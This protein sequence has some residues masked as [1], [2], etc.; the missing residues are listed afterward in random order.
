[1]G[2]SSSFL[3]ATYDGKSVFFATN[4]P[5]VGTDAD[6]AYD[7]YMTREGAG[8]P[9]NA[10]V[11]VPP[12]DGLEACRGKSPQPPAAAPSGSAFFQGR[13]DPSTAP[14]V[15]KL[16]KVATRGPVATLRVKVSGKGRLTATGSGLKKAAKATRKAG[17]YKLQIKL[18]PKA[19]K[20]LNR[21][22]TLKKKVR[23][24][25][26]PSEGRASSVART[27]TFDAPA[28]GNVN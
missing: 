5:I 25:F 22:G 23:V 28:N 13:G 26:T 12:C 18:S 24:T 9:F 19:R 4:D 14:G 1:M 21:K 7:V 8:Y 20:A 2:M 17:V 27:L 6:P 10:V 15:L 3:D 16:A 11:A